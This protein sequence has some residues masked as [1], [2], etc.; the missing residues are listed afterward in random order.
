M[1]AACDLCHA[2][3]NEAHQ[4]LFAPESRDLECVCDACAILFDGQEQKYRRVPRR[5]RFLP[6]FRMADAQWNGLM[7][8]IGIAFLSHNSAADRVTAMYPSPAGPVESELQFETW[9]EI[10][11]DNPE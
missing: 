7:I 4:H 5:V 2:P 10:A 9:N 3:L 11:E 1:S 6:D 8:P